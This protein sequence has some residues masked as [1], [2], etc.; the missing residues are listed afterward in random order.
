[1]KYPMA[2]RKGSADSGSQVR[3]ETS[4]KP[5]ITPPATAPE[6]LPTPPKITAIK[7]LIVGFNPP[8]GYTYF[9]SVIEILVSVGLL[10]VEVVGFTY[11]VKRFP[12]LP[13]RKKTVAPGTLGD[14]STAGQGAA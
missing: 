11:I 2:S 10:A 4:I 8:A 1:M 13:P 5:R 7:A 14:A 9:P 3:S 12:I 6:R